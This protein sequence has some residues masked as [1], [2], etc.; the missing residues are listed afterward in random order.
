MVSLMSYVIS[1]K[2]LGPISTKDASKN[3]VW[4]SA[5]ED[6]LRATE[7]NGSWVLVPLP[8]NCKPIGLQ[9]I[10]NVKK[11]P[12][13]EILRRKA[14]LVVKAYAERFNIDLN[15]LYAHVDKIETIQVLMALYVQYGCYHPNIKT[16]FPNGD[17]SKEI[18]VQ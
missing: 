1:P 17:I 11:T 12:Q 15:E 16:S 18:Y 4:K 10:Y 2:D 7:K 5:M 8:K 6:E 9:R 13:E 14:R 3:Y